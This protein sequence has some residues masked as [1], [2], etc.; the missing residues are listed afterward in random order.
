MIA[1]LLFGSGAGR[2]PAEI[3]AYTET[4]E[5]ASGRSRASTLGIAVL[6][7]VW[8]SNVLYRTLDAPLVLAAGTLAGALLLGADGLWAATAI[9]VQHERVRS[10]PSTHL[11]IEDAGFALPGRD[12]RRV[13]FVATASVAVPAPLSATSDRLWSRQ[14]AAACSTCLCSHY[15]AGHRDQSVLPP[16]CSGSLRRGLVRTSCNARL[17]GTG[18]SQDKYGRILMPASLS[19][20]RT[21]PNVTPEL[22]LWR[23]ERAVWVLRS[24]RRVPHPDRRRTR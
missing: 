18:S 16:T 9:T 21:V 3:A 10:R 8:F 4:T 7:F 2:Q 14:V 5:I 22:S 23:T 20:L 19:A 13:L 12:T 17:V 6:F 11:I 15:L 24:Q 1:V